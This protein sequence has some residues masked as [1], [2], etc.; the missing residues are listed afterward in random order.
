MFE[1]DN[2]LIEKTLVLSTLTDYDIT[3]LNTD[4]VK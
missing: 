1:R 3:Y 2:V 4:I